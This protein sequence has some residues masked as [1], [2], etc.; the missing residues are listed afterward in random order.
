[1]IE[2]L[3][4]DEHNWYITWRFINTWKHYE[5]RLNTMNAFW[6]LSGSSSCFVKAWSNY[7]DFLWKREKNAG[8]ERN[9]WNKIGIR[10]LEHDND[11]LLRPFSSRLSIVPAT[12]ELKEPTA[13][14]YRPQLTFGHSASSSS[15]RY[16][17]RGA[18]KKNRKKEREFIRGQSGASCLFKQT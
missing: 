3:T 9:V 17:L 6:S 8:P 11:S 13:D 5:L 16:T 10:L 15:S 1:M 18:V 12:A 7:L 14:F 4:H 2:W